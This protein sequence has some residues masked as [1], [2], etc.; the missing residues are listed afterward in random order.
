MDIIRNYEEEFYRKIYEEYS[1]SYNIGAQ[2]EDYYD[3]TQ[4]NEELD[5]DSNM[6]ST[7]TDT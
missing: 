4:L 3:S 6:I 7:M 1:G 2:E 5:F